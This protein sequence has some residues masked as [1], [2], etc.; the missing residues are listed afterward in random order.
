MKAIGDIL[1]ILLLL[2][3]A[4]QFSICLSLREIELNVAVSEKLFNFFFFSLLIA[5][6][7]ISQY[8]YNRLK[9]LPNNTS[10]KYLSKHLAQEKLG[11]AFG[12]SSLLYIFLGLITLF[13]LKDNRFF[14]LDYT[15]FAVFLIINGF[16]VIH[17]YRK[18]RF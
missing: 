2:L 1:N 5:L 4:F 16:F 9:I 6:S 8:G 11:K 7:W 18:I 15:K 13:F 10:K 14:L 3:N 17:Y 12:L